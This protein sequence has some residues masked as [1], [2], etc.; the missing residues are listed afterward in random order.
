MSST[1]I[2][3]SPEAPTFVGQL[4]NGGFNTPLY[5]LTIYPDRLVFRYRTEKV[6]PKHG[7]ESV[8]LHRA[9]V[10]G[11]VYPSGVRFWHQSPD[12]HPRLIFNTL[13]SRRL[14]RELE[15]LGYPV[16]PE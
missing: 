1:P 14:I 12:F 5:R 11:W 7:V 8:C 3:P 16:S 13:R 15:R 6:I 2:Q 9:P 10:I 4:R